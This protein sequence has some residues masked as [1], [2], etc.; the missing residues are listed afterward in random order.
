[1]AKTD[2][3][4]LEISQ[5]EARQE[6]AI[7]FEEAR[8]KCACNAPSANPPHRGSGDQ[9]DD[10]IE[11]GDENIPPLEDVP[12]ENATP[13][14]IPEPSPIRF[15]APSP[16]PP[17]E[18][19]N[20]APE[21]ILRPITPPIRSRLV[22]RRMPRRPKPVPHRM[23]PS[24]SFPEIQQYVSSKD[25]GRVRR[26]NRWADACKSAD[27]RGESRPKLEEFF[28]VEYIVSSDSESKIGS[29]PS[30]GPGSRGVPPLDDVRSTRPA[31]LVGRPNRSYHPYQCGR[32][33]R[34]FGSALGEPGQS[35]NA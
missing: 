35:G 8:C 12:Q 29:S 16:L 19:E 1:M 26:L 32:R 24:S 5:E 25:R 17:L 22:A 10:P 23:A 34:A 21:H 6:W 4:R 7:D 2:F 27:R 18:Q 33:G 13:I 28:A 15:A 31:V 11:V 14:P 30:P 20:I 9:Q 3:D